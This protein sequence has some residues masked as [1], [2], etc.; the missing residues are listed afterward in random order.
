[1][2]QQVLSEGNDLQCAQAFSAFSN[3]NSFIYSQAL[4]VQDGPLVSLSGFLDHTHTDT[5]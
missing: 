1:V 5:R 4:I 2:L 3:I